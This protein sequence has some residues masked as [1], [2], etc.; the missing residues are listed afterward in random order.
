MN[1]RKAIAILVSLAALVLLLGS[2]STGK[3]EPGAA[4]TAVAQRVLATLTAEARFTPTSSAAVEAAVQEAFEAWAKE[5]GEPYRDMIVKVEE[6]DSFF[7]QVQ[8]IAWFR[9]SRAAA[10]EER[11]AQIECRQVGGKW[12]CDRQFSFSLTAG[13]QARRAQATATAVAQ[14][15]ATVA[16]AQA[17]AIANMPA[18]LRELYKRLGLEFVYVPAGEFTMGSSEAEMDAAFELCQQTYGGCKRDWFNDEVPQHQ[19]ELDAFWIGKT[20]V[21]NAQWRAFIEA[22]GYSDRDLWTEAGWEWREDGYVT[23]PYCWDYEDWN[24]PDHPVVCVSWYEAMAYTRWLARETGLAVR[25]PAEAE[26][27]KAARGTDA[28]PWP[29]G[30][31]PPDGTRLN[32]CDVSCPY[33]DWKDE[34][35]DDGYATTAPVGSYPAGASP[36]GALDMAGNVWEWTSSFYEDYP[37]RPDDGREALESSACCR[38]VRGGAW[39]AHLLLYARPADRGRDYPDYRGDILGLRVV[40]APQ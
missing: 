17:T 25:L 26:W 7:A 39:G 9:P 23:Q 2:C 35:V 24:Q 28:R 13:E 30:A 38:V 11:A 16:A 37:Y 14:A 18:A 33:D 4:E 22:G 21:T 36:Y 31:E 29:W 8:V 27:E 19:V 10:W 15:T 6:N 5:A 40:V 34:T 1:A 20:E 32:Y 3:E 12:Q